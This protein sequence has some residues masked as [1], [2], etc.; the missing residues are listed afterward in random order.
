MLIRCVRNLIGSFALIGLGCVMGCG[1]AQV[2]T[3][4]VA[5]SVTIKGQPAKNVEIYFVHPKLVAMGKTDETGKFQLV[6]GAVAGE[7][8]VYFKEVAAGAASKFAGQEGVDD[9]QAQMAAGSGASKPVTP[10]SQLPPE[11]TNAV[12]PKLNFVVPGGGT[13]TADFKL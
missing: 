3:E 7:N 9:Y 6:Q 11:Y 13:T 2:R 8:K 12:E 4:P 10:K 5:G 1:E